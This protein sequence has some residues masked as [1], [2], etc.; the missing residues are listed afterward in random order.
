[1]VTVGAPAIELDGAVHITGAVTGDATAIFQ[2]AVTGAGIGLSTHKHLG[3]TAG[4]A[5]SGGPT[6]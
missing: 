4:G 3:V 1:M 5:T 6:P 2:G